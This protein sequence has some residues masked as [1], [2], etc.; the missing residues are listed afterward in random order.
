MSYPRCQVCGT[1][2]ACAGCLS[3]R[4]E[5]IELESF[6]EDLFA[7]TNDLLFDRVCRERELE[8]IHDQQERL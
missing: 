1:E 2:A 8:L 5:C 4:D 7:L 6:A 3:L